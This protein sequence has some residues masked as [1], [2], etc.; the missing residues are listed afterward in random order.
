MGCYR[1]RWTSKEGRGY[2]SAYYRLRLVERLT[3]WRGL[4]QYS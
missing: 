3:E 1:S 4:A 2:P